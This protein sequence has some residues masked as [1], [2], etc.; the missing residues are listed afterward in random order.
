MKSKKKTRKNG[1]H[2]LKA[3]GAALLL[4][5]FGGYYLLF[6]SM[7]KGGEKS[8]VCLDDD[9]NIDSVFTKIAPKATAHSLWAFKKLASVTSYGRHIRTGRYE[10]GREGALQT[11][12]HMRN[13]IQSP[14]N[15]TINSVRTLDRLTEDISRK[16]MFSQENLL[17]KLTDR[18]T[19]EKYGYTPETIIAMFIPNTYDLYW[20]ISVEKFL[21]RM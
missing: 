5:A 3:L 6:S 4:A 11:F 2:L 19:C 13:G 16:L 10:I 15:L 8:Y 12:R 18:A 1:H 21:E 20:N 17:Q 7:A 9:D 14:V